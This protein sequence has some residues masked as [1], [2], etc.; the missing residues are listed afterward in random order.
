MQRDGFR[1]LAAPERLESRCVLNATL[2]IGPG[3][4][5]LVLNSVDSVADH[6]GISQL[7][8]NSGTFHQGDVVILCDQPITVSANTKTSFYT[9]V[10]PNEVVLA[11]G[12]GTTNVPVSVGPGDHLG[13]G[14]YPNTPAQQPFV[15][16]PLG[17][18]TFSGILSVN[19]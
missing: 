15:Q 4:Q 10:S 16:Q 1:R 2:T 8:A 12:I 6:V 9:Q 5:A 3:G 19:V 18:H 13:L 7:Q 14:A 17:T 11:D